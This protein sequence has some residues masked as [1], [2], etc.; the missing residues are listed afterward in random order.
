[1]PPALRYLFWEPLGGEVLR[2]KLVKSLRVPPVWGLAQCQMCLLGKGERH[3]KKR[4]WRGFVEARAHVRGLGLRSTAEWSAFCTS[5]NLPEDI[6]AMPGRVYKGLGWIS[7]GDWLG[8]GTIAPYKRQFLNFEEARDVVRAHC[9][10]TKTEYEA[11]AQSVVV[12]VL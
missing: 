3:S 6:P 1:M 4:K 7:T 11:W 5:G 9:F 12:P 8:T 2:G 10:R